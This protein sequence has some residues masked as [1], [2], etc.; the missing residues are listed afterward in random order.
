[1]ALQLGALR[2][3]YRAAE[4]LEGHENRLA[5]LDV[6]LKR[7]EGRLSLVQA[8]IGIVLAGVASLVIKAFL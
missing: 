3:A 1:M 8:L 6:R 2:L 4:E 7:I 5:G